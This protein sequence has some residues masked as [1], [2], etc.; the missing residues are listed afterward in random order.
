MSAVTSLLAPAVLGDE[1]PNGSACRARRNGHRL[2][3]TMECV[4]YTH[5]VRLGELGSLADEEL[6]DGRMP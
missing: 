1:E 2:E 3:A 6:V 4:R 5:R